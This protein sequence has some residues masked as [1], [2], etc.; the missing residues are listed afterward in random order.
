MIL[1]VHIV[2]IVGSVMLNRFRNCTYL[3][4]LQMGRGR[5]LGEDLVDLIRHLVR[6]II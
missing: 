6:T 2:M 1:K 3:L 5:A 4:Q